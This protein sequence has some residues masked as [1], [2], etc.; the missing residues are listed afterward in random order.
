MARTL[1]EIFTQAKEARNNYL[2]L[3]EF[4]ND[5]KM[6]VIDAFTWVSSACIWTFENLLDVF[7]VDLAR[8]LQ[9]RINGTHCLNINQ[10]TNC[11]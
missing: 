2:Q 10:A 9:N 11:R 1:T 5:S 7:K 8:D 6:S 3:T 4:E